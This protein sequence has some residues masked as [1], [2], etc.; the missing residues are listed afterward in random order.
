MRTSARGNVAEAAI[1][2]ELVRR[3]FDVLVPFGEG[4]PYDLALIA[5]HS[6]YRHQINRAARREIRRALAA[7]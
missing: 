4:Q 7:G 3:K 5:G 6:A 2:S 1:L